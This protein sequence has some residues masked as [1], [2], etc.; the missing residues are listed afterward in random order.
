MN[1]MLFKDALSKHVSLLHLVRPN[2]L[3]FT[4]EVHNNINHKFLAKSECTKTLQNKKHLVKNVKTNLS[5][6]YIAFTYSAFRTFRLQFE[7]WKKV[8]KN[9]P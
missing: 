1:E 4:R 8:D 2:Y 6:I 7:N 9:F 5:L 3:F